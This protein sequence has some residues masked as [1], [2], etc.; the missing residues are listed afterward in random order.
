M[1]WRCEE[2]GS[3]KTIKGICYDCDSTILFME[4]E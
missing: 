4:E 2:C 1:T 3:D